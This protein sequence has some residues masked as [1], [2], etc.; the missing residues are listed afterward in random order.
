MIELLKYLTGYDKVEIR[1]KEIWVHPYF[2]SES[3]KL[4]HIYSALTNTETIIEITT[5]AVTIYRAL[6]ME[7]SLE[8]LCSLKK[9]Y[10]T[11]AVNQDEVYALKHWGLIVMDGYY[12]CSIT[13]RGKEVIECLHF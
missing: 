1:G 6:R 12:F 11:A 10:T 7:M 4:L 3:G 5:A 13:P 2:I 8:V 9:L